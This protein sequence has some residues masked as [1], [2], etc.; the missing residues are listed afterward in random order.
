MKLISMRHLIQKKL[1]KYKNINFIW[2]PTFKL[3]FF[4]IRNKKIRNSEKRKAKKFT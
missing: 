2:L 1:T 4:E 3:I